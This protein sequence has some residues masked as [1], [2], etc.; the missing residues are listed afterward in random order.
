MWL[1]AILRHLYADAPKSRSLDAVQLENRVLMSATPLAGA[2][3]GAEPGAEAP[4]TAGLAVATRVAEATDG[5]QAG[6]EAGGA[7]NRTSG[8]GHDDDA[9]S[10]RF[11]SEKEAQQLR[12]ELIVIDGSTD[13]YQQLIDD[14]RDQDDDSRQYEVHLLEADRDGI[15]QISELLADCDQ[16]DAVHV[17]SHGTGGAVK[18]G[19]SWIDSGNL[20]AYSQE[21]VGWQS[22]LSTEADLLFYG[23]DLASNQ[24]GQVLV[25]SLGILTGAD[26]AASTDA[27]G[28][29]SLGGDWDLEHHSGAIESK[30]AF[31]S[32]LQGEWMSTLG[33]TPVGGETLV[34]TMTANDQKESSVA[35]DADGN[36]VVVWEGKDNKADIYFQRYDSHGNA[37][38][39]ETLV[40]TTTSGNQKKPRVAMDA[41]GDFVIV[42][43]GKGTQA[44][45]VDSKGVF[46]QRFDADGVAQGGETLVNTTTASD[47]KEAD[48]AMDDDGNFAV[49]WESKAGTKSDIYL[50]RFDADG[51]AQGGETIVNTTMNG[52]QKKAAL[53]MDAEGNIVVVWQGA[54]EQLG[55]IDNKGIFLQ[56]FD[57]LGVAQGGETLVNTTTT[58]DQ[59][60]ADVAMDANGQFAVVWEGE[61]TDESDIFLQRYDASG[62]AQ[63]GETQVNT[64]TAKDQKKASIAMNSSGDFLVAWEGKGSGDGRGVFAQQFDSSGARVDGEF[65]GNTTTNKSQTRAATAM[66]DHGNFVLVWDGQGSGD[67]KGVFSQRYQKSAPELDLNGSVDGA[68]FV[69]TFV[70][71]GGPVLIQH[72]DATLAH[73]DDSTLSS[74]TVTITNPLD[75]A[76]ESLSADTSGTGIS[77]S[78]SGGVLTLTGDD[79]LDHYQQVLRSLSYNNQSD[80]PATAERVITVVANDGAQDSNVATAT[81]SV[82]AVND[83]P[84]INAP[85][86]QITDEDASFVFGAAFGNP[87]SIADPDAGV[88]EVEVTLT[89]THGQL[90]LSD[91]TGLEFV[92]GDG[93]TAATLRFTGSLADINQALDGMWFHPNEDFNGAASLQVSVDDLAGG[94]ALTDTRTIAIEVNPV[95]D[96]PVAVGESYQ[97]K[98]HQTLTVGASGLLANDSDIDGDSLS[99]RLISG[100]S[101][102]SLSLAADGSF[103]YRPTPLYDGQVSFSYVA[104]DGSGTSNVVLVTIDVEAGFGPVEVEEYE[105]YLR[106]HENIEFT[107]IEPYD[108]PSIVSINR[109]SDPQPN[110]SRKRTM[111]ESSPVDVQILATPYL[112]LIESSD[113][114]VFLY[115][116]EGEPVDPENVETEEPVVVDDSVAYVDPLTFWDRL[117]QLQQELSEDPLLELTAGS[118]A[119]TSLAVTGGYL[120]WTSNSGLMLAGLMSQAPSFPWSDRQSMLQ[121]EGA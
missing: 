22:S 44:G 83:A 84:A 96:L 7:E 110:A 42:W 28:H 49:V 66:S 103:T 51:N 48:V 86:P 38:G 39:D 41:D 85:G 58:A 62:V 18:L 116:S 16:L 36:Y 8:S 46:F 95:N 78:Y 2:I 3:A 105:R 99:V 13:D 106:P 77:M 100:P 81:V 111:P 35:M 10:F 118:V 74:M 11:H 70:E 29:A 115:T 50:Q 9:K 89:A 65:R 19:N 15:A 113:D 57:A 17:V 94:A 69:T 1:R 107:E 54:G 87:I 104:D 76:L 67:D 32:E 71:D 60:E 31:S 61:G 53:D 79:T 37:V 21:L 43:Q 91:T 55:N 45:N 25:E 52:D 109:D 72:S 47:E 112:P 14:L 117:D 6:G 92:G 121:F 68:D 101:A 20:S 80:S 97:I 63:G 24:D 93:S 88:S 23:C 120:L 64:T 90:T 12:K 34:N 40:N 98:S 82:T 114:D 5:A 75:G 4:D 108:R 30:L 59:K 26:V 73:P 102:G 27:T 119:M 33:A 56:R